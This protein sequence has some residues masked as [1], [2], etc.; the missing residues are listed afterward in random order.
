MMPQTKAF[1]RNS[2]CKYFRVWSVPPFG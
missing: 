2:F 1:G